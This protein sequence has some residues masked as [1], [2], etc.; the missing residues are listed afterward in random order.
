MAI[1]GY[2]QVPADSTGKK[3]DTLEL[4]TSAG[5]VERQRIDVPSYVF[6]SGD[7][8]ANAVLDLRLQSI[9]LAQ[10][11]NLSVDLDDVRNGIISEYGD[12]TDLAT[13]SQ[14]D[15]LLFG[16]ANVSAKALSQGSL[17]LD[18]GA[19][20]VQY[21]TNNAAFTITAPTRDGF[22]MVLVTN[23]ASAGA[24]TFTG[25]SVGSSTGD[26]ITTTSASK[27]TISFW[28]INSISGYRILAHQ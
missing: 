9:L 8:L 5:T 25:F 20:P 15:Q 14:E 13:L 11:L 6:V 19:R 7:L 12:F 28:R 24:I 4:A 17:T 22:C 26:T 10:G 23:G 2:I 1:D 16:G 3:V 27:F 21:I 18:C